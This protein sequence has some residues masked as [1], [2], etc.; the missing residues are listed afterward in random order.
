MSLGL[1]FRAGIRW[2]YQGG[3]ALCLMGVGLTLLLGPFACGGTPFGPTAVSTTAMPGDVTREFSGEI[4]LPPPVV[5]NL[6]L[7]IRGLSTEASRRFPRFVVPLLAQEVST[8]DGN[9]E[10]GVNPPRQGRIEGTLTGGRSGFFTGTLTEVRNGCEAKREFSGQVTL[11]G[12]N[13]AAGM[14]VAPCPDNLLEF[15]EMKL[16]STSLDEPVAASEPEFHVLTVSLGG[17]G[18]GAVPSSPAGIDCAGG[19]EAD[20]SQRYRAGT[21]VTLTAISDE[22]SRFDEWNGACRGSGFTVNVTLDEATS[23]TAVFELLEA[24]ST[25]TGLTVSGLAGPLAIGAT[26][27]LAATASYGDS[28]T[29]AVTATWS[30]NNTAVATVSTAGVVTAVAAGTA[31]I[32]AE[33]EGQRA[34][35]TVTVTVSAPVVTGLS[36]AVGNTQLEVGH[37]ASLTATATYNNGDTESVIPDWTTD[38][39]SVVSILGSGTVVAEAIGT[40]VVTGTYEDHSDSVTVTVI[41][42]LRNLNVLKA[43]TGTGDVVSSPSGINC[44]NDCVEDYEL[45]TDVTLTADPSPGSLFFG[46]SGDCGTNALTIAVTMDT[47]KVC[48]ATFTR[49]SRLSVSKAGYGIGDVVSSPSGINCGN[50]CIEDYGPETDVTLTATPSTGYIFSGWSGDCSSNASTITIKMTTSK[51]CTATFDYNSAQNFTTNPIR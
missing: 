29:G 12:L 48:T 50:D 38:V 3:V 24:S 11:S 31:E 36:V 40:V 9:W 27:Q 51:E 30:S 22:G 4:V 7:V 17:T 18:A 42:A 19:A 20:C 44:G 46:W 16:V 39:S 15:G 37:Q 13:W 14:M 41:A 6:T 34:S 23:C 28:T 1:R 49:L 10:I 8:V 47:S 21:E 25:V 33:Y 45:G 43:G 26:A 2:L 32:T 35:V 5:M